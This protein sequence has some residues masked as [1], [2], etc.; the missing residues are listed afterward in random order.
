MHEQKKNITEPPELTH[1]NAT[2]ET[3]RILLQ[4]L[5]YLQPVS[6]VETLS[7]LAAPGDRARDPVSVQEKRPEVSIALIH[8]YFICRLINIACVPGK[9]SFLLW[10]PCFNLF[11][12][13]AL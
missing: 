2:E 6:R 4:R 7:S 1:L 11:I 8:M 10:M 9:A 3:G 13:V 5:R 12:S